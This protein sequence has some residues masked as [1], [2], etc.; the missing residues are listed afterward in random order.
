MV[1]LEKTSSAPAR[2]FC[3]INV[4]KLHF[5]PFFVSSSQLR[6]SVV[7]ARIPAGLRLL[8]DGSTVDTTQEK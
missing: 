8:R 3:A 1:G 5:F 4:T 2:G 6:L 7:R